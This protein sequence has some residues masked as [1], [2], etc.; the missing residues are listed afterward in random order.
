MKIVSVFHVPY[1]SCINFIHSYCDV[2]VFL[3]SSA[4]KG[5]LRKSLTSSRVTCSYFEFFL[6][7]SVILAPLS[8][9]QTCHALHDRNRQRCKN[10]NKALPIHQNGRQKINQDGKNKQR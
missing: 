6:T 4:E 2:F 9:S 3:F 1:I 7:N 5:T 10:V 8:Q